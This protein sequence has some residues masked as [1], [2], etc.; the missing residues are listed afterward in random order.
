[1]SYTE[2][3]ILSF[4]SSADGAKFEADL[5]KIADFIRSFGFKCEG[6]NWC[7]LDLSTPE[8]DEMLDQI[9]Q[10]CKQTGTK[11]KGHYT[12][13]YCAADSEWYRLNFDVFRDYE[14]SDTF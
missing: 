13:E 2:A 14:T 1:M 3:L 8:C 9:G 12:R 11:A 4:H 10:F 5:E 7:K 6:L